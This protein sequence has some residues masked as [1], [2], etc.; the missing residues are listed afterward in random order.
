MVDFNARV[1][2]CFDCY[3]MRNDSAHCFSCGSNFYY[4]FSLIDLT[5][6][7]KSKAR[8]MLKYL[9]SKK[10]RIIYIL[11]LHTQM[12]ENRGIRIFTSM[13]SHWSQGIIR[14]IIKSG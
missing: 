9:P 1:R 12:F 13:N 2:V 3:S 14:G 7:E 11:E 8:T 5:E 6:N 10:D 4:Y